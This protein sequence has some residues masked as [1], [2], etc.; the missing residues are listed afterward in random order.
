[1]KGMLDRIRTYCRDQDK[2]LRLTV[3]KDVLPKLYHNLPTDLVGINFTERIFEMI[4]DSE[5]IVKLAALEFLFGNC[6]L[7]SHE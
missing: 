5:P 2:E 7:F 3:L 4:Y 1:M 6:E